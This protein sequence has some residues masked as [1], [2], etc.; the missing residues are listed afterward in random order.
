VFEAMAC[1]APCVLSDLPWVHEQIAHEREALIVPISQAEVGR[2]IARLL[3]DDL[4]IPARARAFVERE[5]DSDVHMNR[6]ADAYRSL[7]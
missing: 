3:D 7:L 4:G 1:G 6:L 2:A 5:H